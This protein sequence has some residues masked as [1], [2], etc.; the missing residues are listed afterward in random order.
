MNRIGTV[1]VAVGVLLVLLIIIMYALWRRA[2]DNV[3]LRD[4]T[5]TSE[6][7]PR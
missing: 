6:G 7:R 1:Y 2:V 4:A 3:K 5:L